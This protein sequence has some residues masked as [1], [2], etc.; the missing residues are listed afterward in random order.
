MLTKNVLITGAGSGFGRG[1]A[2]ALASR[3]HHVIATT[4]DDAQA[5]E[6]A[7]AHPELTVQRLDITDPADRARAG[8]WD[9][10]VL[11]NNAGAGQL[12]TLVQVPLDLVRRVFEVNVFGTLA[13]TQVVAPRMMERGSGRIIVVSS[14]AGL[15]DAAPASGPYS[16]TKHALQALGSSLR[17]ELEP[18]G[19]DVCLLN[20]GPYGTGFND[21][22][23]NHPGDWF[24]AVGEPEHAMLADLRSLITVDQLDPREVVD[25]MVA[26]VEADTTELSNPVPPNIV[27]LITGAAG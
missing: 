18:Y 26:L 25:T 19:V 27:E 12:G 24:D 14:V 7:A 2:V 23:A 3:G 15:L 9:V 5:E 8:E 21:A 22:M 20:P 16:M 17:G 4:Y 11:L 10:D 13:V 6:L 1:A